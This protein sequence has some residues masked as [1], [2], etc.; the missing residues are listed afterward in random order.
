MLGMSRLTP[1]RLKIAAGLIAAAAIV[2][3]VALWLWPSG[4]D[5]PPAVA[6]SGFVP[7]PRIEEARALVQEVRQRRIQEGRYACCCTEPCTLC[8][9][10]NGTCSCAADAVGARVTCE[11]CLPKLRGMLDPEGKID[12]AKKD[13]RAE[14]LAQV[15]PGQLRAWSDVPRG[16]G[17]GTLGV[18]DPNNPCWFNRQDPQIQKALQIMRETKRRLNLRS[19]PIYGCCCRV[20][21]NDC[22]LATGSCGCRLS[23]DQTIVFS[24]A[25]AGEQRIEART[26]PECY[27]TWRATPALGTATLQPK[28]DDPP[29]LPTQ[30]ELR[31]TGAPI[32]HPATLPRPR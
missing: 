12:P 5:S 20:P 18:R 23:I 15:H 22:L 4:D 25:Q 6:P 11:E 2:A 28:R 7:D 24:S 31:S 21:C 13:I 27:R 30:N 3:S 10:E 9:L 16:E 26:C 1:R 29:R 8:L 19:P 17:E 32:P 14:P